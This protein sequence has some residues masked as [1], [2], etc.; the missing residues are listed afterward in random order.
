MWGLAGS[1]ASRARALVTTEAMLAAFGSAR[2]RLLIRE[3]ASISTSAE[4]P[5]SRLV[6]RGKVIDRALH[7]GAGCWS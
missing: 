6:E 2:P 5:P 3:N 4:A 1:A 7:V